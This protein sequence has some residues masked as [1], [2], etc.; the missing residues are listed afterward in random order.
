MEVRTKRKKGM[1]MLPFKLNRRFYIRK[2]LINKL[3]KKKREQKKRRLERENGKYVNDSN[4]SSNG[5]SD[6]SSDGNSDCSSN[7]SSDGSSDNSSDCSSDGSTNSCDEHNSKI[8]FQELGVENW[9][10]KICNSVNIFYPTRIQQLC[11]PL[12]IKEN[13]NVIGSSDTGT[14]K[15]ICYCFS[16][17][18]DLNKNMCSIFALILLPTRELVFQV[19]DIFQLYGIKIGVKILSCIGGF[20]LIEQRKKIYHKPHIVIGTPGRV[21]DILNNCEDIKIYF[22][23]LKYIVLDE[24]DLLLQEHFENHLKI[25]LNNLPQDINNERKTLFFSSTIT[26]S[27][28]LLK[29]TF[30]NNNDIKK[31]VLINVNKKKKPLKNLDQRFLYID[32]LVQLNY[33]IYILQNKVNNLSGIIFA[34]NSYKCEL[35]CNV[36]QMSGIGSVVS[37]HTGKDQQKRISSLLRF[38]NGL[39]KILVAT[40]LI[41]RGI[42]I[43]HVAFVINFDFPNDVTQYIHRVGRTARANK[44]GLAISFV[45]KKDKQVF[46]EV[47]QIMKKKLK[48]YIIDK[49]DVLNNLFKTGKIIKMAELKLEEQ[50]E[51]KRD[52]QT[53]KQ[54]VFRM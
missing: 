5:S 15:T 7:G 32:T 47:K 29:N 14:G 11:L 41:S 39:C 33:L 18:Q 21:S 40:D 27:L 23:R 43:P 36:L 2:Y 49:Q 24:A 30:S 51:I 22:K 31:L 20:S 28:H 1:L 42:D 16:I 10:I 6:G 13:R 44:K 25:I 19:V 50:K 17:L 52:I 48:P 53:L 46:N 26:E 37:I 3:K 34:A 38:K 8:T 9:L 4:G 35:I 12:I 45:D 54:R